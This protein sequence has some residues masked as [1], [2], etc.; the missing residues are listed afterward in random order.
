MSCPPSVLL[1]SNHDSTSI[2]QELA[3]NQPLSVEIQALKDEN[4]AL[5]DEMRNVCEQVQI[6]IQ[7]LLDLLQV[8]V[9]PIHGTV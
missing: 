9:E 2:P 1:Q 5:K 7:R 4:Q 3:E 6:R 8:N